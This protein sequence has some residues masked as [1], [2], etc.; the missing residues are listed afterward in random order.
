MRY[1]SIQLL[2]DHPPQQPTRPEPA[3]A[4]SGGRSAHPR[5]A[6]DVE[7]VGELRGSGFADQQWLIRRD[8][9]YIQLT[10]LLYR[11]AE[12]ANG[13]RSIEEIA[14]R[15]TAATDWIVEAEQV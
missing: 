4:S 3:L 8:G 12:Q 5:L 1:P 2:R 6:Q 15:V 13:E 10:E 9:R 7:L 14:E 11:V